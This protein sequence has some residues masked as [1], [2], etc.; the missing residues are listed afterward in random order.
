MPVLGPTIEGLAYNLPDDVT[1]DDIIGPDYLTFDL[2]DPG[3]RRYLG[4]SALAAPAFR[5]E[6]PFVD[7]GQFRS[8]YSVLVAGHRFGR[9]SA[10]VH[11]AMALAEAGVQA[12]L[13]LSFAEGFLRSAVNAGLLY[14]LIAPPGLAA[15]VRTGDCVRIDWPAGRV[16]LSDDQALH[17]PDPG[18]VPEIVRDGGLLA[19]A[20]RSESR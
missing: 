13:A 18:V 17:L 11:T 4:A 3:E 2:D 5:L 12:V 9:G 19:H 16:V 10:R 14:P 20:R 8:R 7:A 6:W 15:R 1:A